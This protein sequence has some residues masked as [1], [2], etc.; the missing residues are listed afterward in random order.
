MRRYIP[1]Q[2]PSFGSY[3]TEIQ[4]N[5]SGVRNKERGGKLSGVSLRKARPII[6]VTNAILGV[7]IPEI[8]FHT[9]RSIAFVIVQDYAP[10]VCSLQ[11]IGTVY[12][13]VY[14]SCRINELNAYIY[15]P[16]C[17]VV[18]QVVNLVR[19]PKGVHQVQQSAPV[20]EGMTPR[21]LITTPIFGRYCDCAIR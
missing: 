20:Q 8:I 1:K 16:V 7:Q 4:R 10:Y 9:R 21:A 3:A 15:M 12:L 18:N 19:W 13:E 14:A 17:R 6:I 5:L 2:C 11:G